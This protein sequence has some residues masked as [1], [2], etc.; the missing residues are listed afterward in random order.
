LLALIVLLGTGVAASADTRYQRTVEN[1]T[2]P[3][4][5]LVDQQGKKVRL[6]ELLDVDKAVLV[7]FVYATCTTICPVLSAGFSSFQRRL[8]DEASAPHLISI[9]IDPEHD[10][11]ELMAAYLGR[12]RAKPG[13]D[14]LTGTREDIDLVMHAF[15][16]YIANKMDHYPITFLKGPGKSEWVRIYGLLGT[17]DLIKEYRALL[18]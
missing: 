6:R 7:D 3:D 13:W 15:D 4:V 18:P 9:T 16:A 12:Y 11:P 10:T 2:I 5:V 14:F 1:Y 17:A 8:G